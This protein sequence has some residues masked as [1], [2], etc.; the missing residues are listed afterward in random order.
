VFDKDGEEVVISRYRKHSDFENGLKLSLGGQEVTGYRIADTQKKIEEI[1][2]VSEDLFNSLVAMTY[3]LSGSFSRL[4]PAQRVEVLESLGV[5]QN[6]DEMR[7]RARTDS[8]ESK[9]EMQRLQVSLSGLQ[10][11]LVEKKKRLDDLVEEL[12]KTPDVKELSEQKASADQEVVFLEKNLEGIQ[13]KVK[14]LPFKISETRDN[15]ANTKVGIQEHNN[16]L[17]KKILTLSSEESNNNKEI[18][19]IKKTLESGICP[20]CK[21]VIKSFS[22]SEKAEYTSKIIELEGRNKSINEEKDSLSKSRKTTTPEIEDYAKL[23]TQLESE[24]LQINNVVR[25]MRSKIFTA[26]TQSSVIEQKVLILSESKDKLLIEREIKLKEIDF[27]EGE[28]KTLTA[29]ARDESKKAAIADYFFKTLSPG[30]GLRNKILENTIRSL[31]VTLHKYISRLFQNSFVEMEIIDKNIEIKFKDVRGERSVETL[32][33]GEMRRV[34]LAI[35]FAILTLAK[36][37]SKTDFNFLVLDEVGIGL[38]V[39]GVQQMISLLEVLQGRIPS[40]YVV[41]NDPMFTNAIE[42]RILVRK[43]G[44]ESRVVGNN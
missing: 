6:Y 12:S 33:Q 42:T 23:I 9:R 38:D 18:H 28:Q 29:R 1:L 30:G 2:G 31:N 43:Q 44:G 11:S 35:Q 15:L 39:V 36:N 8:A 27:V 41:S 7:N 20:A 19:T 14:E 3:D 16:E 4:T 40:I 5:S 25:E 32:S 22:E 26:K 10:G 21:S 17:D 13:E 37:C 34:D 24:H